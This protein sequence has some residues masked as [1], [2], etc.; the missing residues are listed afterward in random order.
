[1]VVVVVVVGPRTIQRVNDE[2]RGGLIWAPQLGDDL[3]RIRSAQSP[4]VLFTIPHNQHVN[5]MRRAVRDR[6]LSIF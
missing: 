5:D 2:W 4:S 6:S 3:D 1:V